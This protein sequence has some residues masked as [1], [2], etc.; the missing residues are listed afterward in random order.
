MRSNRDLATS[1]LKNFRKCKCR[2][3]SPGKYQSRTEKSRLTYVY[4]TLLHGQARVK[5]EV[6]QLQSCQRSRSELQ[7]RRTQ[8]Q[9]YPPSCRNRLLRYRR[10]FKSKQR[11]Q[12]R[13]KS[14]FRSQI[15]R[16]RTETSYC[17]RL[18]PP[19]PQKDCPLTQVRGTNHCWTNLEH[20]DWLRHFGKRLSDRTSAP[21]E[22]IWAAAAWRQLRQLNPQWPHLREPS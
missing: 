6:A 11:R 2:R 12:L 20:L 22:F 21:L 3:P 8:T 15:K 9:V 10:L 1:W 19:I 16:M 18:Q 14:C 17:R 4:F 5:K 13:N 7:L